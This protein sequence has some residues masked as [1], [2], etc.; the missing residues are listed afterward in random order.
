[1]FKILGE[2][3]VM[4]DKLRPEVRRVLFLG[5]GLFGF[6]LPRP[7]VGSRGAANANPR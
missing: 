5:T 1:M 7:F 6:L 3:K 2:D 4:V